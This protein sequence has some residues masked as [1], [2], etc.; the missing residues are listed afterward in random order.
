VEDYRVIVDNYP[1]ATKLLNFDA[2]L[3]DNKVKLNWTAAE[4][5]GIYS[6]EIERST[7]NTN[8]SVIDAV[9][10]HDAAGNYN[11]QAVDNNPRK[12]TSYYRLKII[13]STGMN[14]YSIIKAIK[15]NEF[16]AS[17]T[18]APNPANEKTKLLID[19]NESREATIEIFNM[20][21]KMI[22]SKMQRVNSGANSIELTLTEAFTSGT[23]IVKTSVGEQTLYRKL[24]VNK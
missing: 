6:Y 11:Y 20:Q 23:Y 13:E 15:F 4:E 5:T 18:I 19:I 1:L 9:K 24:I 8:W 7:D 21:G 14:R 2:A 3:Q 22:Y 10:A 12:G 17:F 16:N